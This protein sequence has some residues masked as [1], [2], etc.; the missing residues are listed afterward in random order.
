MQINTKHIGLGWIA[1]LG[2][3]ALT[4]STP[5]HATPNFP[6][7]IQ[8]YLMLDAQPECTLCHVGTQRIGSVNTAFGRLARERGLMRYNVA[9]LELA[10]RAI[11]AENVDSNG[12]GVPDIMQLRMGESPNPE[13]ETVP[14][15]GCGANVAP[16]R[17]MRLLDLL[18]PIALVY[19]IRRKQQQ[20]SPRS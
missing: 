12:D 17:P 20:N 3:L 14:A 19:W 11:E 13:D 4:M 15:Y 2:I 18:W 7:A 16:Y 9:S 8:S 5:A 1:A 10:L 6:P